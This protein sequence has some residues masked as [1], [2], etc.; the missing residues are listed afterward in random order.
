MSL[1]KKSPTS[2]DRLAMSTNSDPVN[3]T[4]FFDPEADEDKRPGPTKP[5]TKERSPKSKRKLERRKKKLS[6]KHSK[7]IKWISIP[8]S[9]TKPSN[10]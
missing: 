8:N 5:K 3:E 10:N 9:R 6:K 1:P 2:T 4:L 7:K